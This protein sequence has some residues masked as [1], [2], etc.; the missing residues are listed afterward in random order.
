MS[1]ERMVF[2][3]GEPGIGGLR[4]SAG[5][6]RMTGDLGTGFSMRGSLLRTTHRAWQAPANTSF[7]GLEVQWF[8]LFALGVRVGV[9]VPLRDSA[10]RRLLTG[11]IGFAL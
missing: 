8:P 10:R 1:K 11:D 7:G 2:L 6:A 9:F 3:A 4:V 5:Y